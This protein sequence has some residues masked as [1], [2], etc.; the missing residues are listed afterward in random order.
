MQQEVA[1]VGSCPGPAAGPDGFMHGVHCAW[2]AW[3]ACMSLVAH[4]HRPHVMHA[5][6]AW[7]ACMWLHVCRRHA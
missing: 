2:A 7:H 6:A 5:W 4:M 3:H 1:P